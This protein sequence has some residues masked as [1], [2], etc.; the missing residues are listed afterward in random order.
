VR[1]IGLGEKSKRTGGKL[2]KVRCLLTSLRRGGKVPANRNAA[3]Q[4]RPYPLVLKRAV[5]A[6]R[7][8]K[9]ENRKSI[10]RDVSH[11]LP[12]KKMG[13]CSNGKGERE[14]KTGTLPRFFHLEEKKINQDESVP[15][16]A[17]TESK[18]GQV[19]RPAFPGGGREKKKVRKRQPTRTPKNTTHL[20]KEVELPCT[21][22]KEVEE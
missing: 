14:K 13:G 5:T 21:A 16:V 8:K 4:R 2:Q 20:P 11:R 22:F 10:A 17:K 3:G 12:P 18:R 9:E 15:D 6:N 1:K 7:K 19:R